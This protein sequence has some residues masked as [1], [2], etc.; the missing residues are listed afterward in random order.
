MSHRLFGLLAITAVG[1]LLRLVGA[2][3][4]SL[5]SD[6][7]LTLV[8]A[9]WPL[10]TLFLAPADP[11]PGLYYALHKLVLGPDVGVVAARSISI[12]AGTLLI[13]AAYWLAREARVP[14]LLIAALVA[15]SFPLIDYSQE[16]R[17]YSLLVLLVVLSAAAFARW[18]RLQWTPVLWASLAFALL[19]FYTHFAAIFWTGPL[20]VAALWLGKRSAAAPV[21]GLAVLMVPELARLAQYPAGHFSWLAQASL[22]EAAD[23]LARNLLPFQ[24]PL[25]IAVGILVL[26]GWRAWMHRSAL[27]AWAAANRGAAAALLILCTIP[28][29]VWLFGFVAKP[30]FMTRTILL[31]IP[32]LLL[33]IS[34]LMRFEP[35]FV[36][37]ALVGALAASLLVSGTMRERED[38][39]EIAGRVRGG[40]VLVCELWQ[41][42]AMLSALERKAAIVPAGDGLMLVAGSPWAVAYFRAVTNP[43]AQRRA[44]MAG[45]RIGPDAFPVWA[46]PSGS[47]E[48]LP[49]KPGSLADT[50]G[51]CESRAGR[52]APAY[53]A[54]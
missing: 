6:E 1:L 11:T 2:D 35:R 28:L 7:A 52:D 48:D 20:A 25:P 24:P 29:T 22:V 33:A 4:W 3:R 21:V 12:V 13:P 30:I 10:K 19:A 38:W 45:R 46:V 53:R 27:K 5:W 54:D 9:Q 41:A 15:L 47:V 39:R 44:L 17:A 23:T 49:D 42:P 26:L 14:A 43:Q 37:F 50:I 34:L 32:G 8:I 36:R 18:H 40:A 16:A 51:I 31:A